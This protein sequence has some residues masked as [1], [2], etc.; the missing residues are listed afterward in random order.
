MCQGSFEV[1]CQVIAG[2]LLFGFCWLLTAAC[3]LLI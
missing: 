1:D 2:V 3:C